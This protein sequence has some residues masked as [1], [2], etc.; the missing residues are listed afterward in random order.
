MPI[1]VAA[2]AAGAAALPY[3]LKIPKYAKMLYKS[4]HFIPALLGA[5]YFGSMG[6]E[7]AG[8]AGERRAVDAGAQRHGSPRR[9]GFG[10]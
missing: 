7:A 3:V 2:A 4:K 5:G 9:F 8:Q 1:P 6:L 10:N